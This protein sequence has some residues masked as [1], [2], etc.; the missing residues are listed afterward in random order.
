M[1][2][3]VLK[4]KKNLYLYIQHFWKSPGEAVSSGDLTEIRGRGQGDWLRLSF[5]FIA[6]R[7][8]LTFVS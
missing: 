2:P 7:S 6:F 1:V 4:E 3:F 8:V 5:H